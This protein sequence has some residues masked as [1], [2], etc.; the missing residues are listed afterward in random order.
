MN[1]LRIY[2]HQYRD[3]LLESVVPFWLNNSR[4]NICASG[5]SIGDSVQTLWLPF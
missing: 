5:R 3:E 1:E 2:A 4:D